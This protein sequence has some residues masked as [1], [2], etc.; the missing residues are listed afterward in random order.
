MHGS[1]LC[2]RDQGDLKEQKQ[3]IIVIEFKSF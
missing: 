1:Y 3:A 2:I